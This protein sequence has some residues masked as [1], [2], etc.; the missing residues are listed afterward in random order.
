MT[1]IPPHAAQNVRQTSVCAL[2][3]TATSRQSQQRLIVSSP[4]NL[5]VNS[6]LAN[7]CFS[8]HYKIYQCFSQ[9]SVGVYLCCQEEMLDFFLI[10]VE[11]NGSYV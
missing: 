3:W 11:K 1:K 7:Y 9:Q 6:Q 10:H 4:Q 5:L 2:R 8:I